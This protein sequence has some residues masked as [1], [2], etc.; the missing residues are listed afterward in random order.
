MQNFQS[1]II[2]IA[3][4]R[5]TS[6]EFPLVTI[7]AINFFNEIYFKIISILSP[8]IKESLKKLIEYKHRKIWLRECEEKVS[9][10]K[11]SSIET[12]FYTRTELILEYTKIAE[13]FRRLNSRVP[14]IEELIYLVFVLQVIT[15]DIFIS[16]NTH[17]RQPLVTNFQIVK[18]MK[19]VSYLSFIE[20]LISDTVFIPSSTYCRIMQSSQYKEMMNKLVNFFSIYRKARNNKPYDPNQIETYFISKYHGYLAF[21]NEAKNISLFEL[22]ISDLDEL[23]RYLCSILDVKFL[24][25]TNDSHRKTVEFIT[26]GKILH[27]IDNLCIGLRIL[28]FPP[29]YLNRCVMIESTMT[30][31]HDTI[32]QF[33][34]VKAEN[35]Y[36][37]IR[38]IKS[39]GCSD[40][41]MLEFRLQNK[42]FITKTYK[43]LMEKFNYFKKFMEAN[44]HCSRLRIYVDS[45]DNISDFLRYKWSGSINFNL[46]NLNY[47]RIAS[48]EIFCERYKIELLGTLCKGILV[49]KNELLRN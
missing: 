28:L 38:K 36:K 44:P 24:L 5:F 3:V 17:V 29:F 39:E 7:D 10:Y 14:T 15:E 16:Y 43:A 49:C 6:C 30:K 33:F 18:A 31:L 22:Y 25:S 34:T 42:R 41:I 2:I 35:T 9:Q 8:D 40:E 20:P 45:E 13:I 27:P 48:L 1:S 11:K 12:S 32:N 19:F 26:K 4:L 37:I 46:E 23:I 47:E 21:K